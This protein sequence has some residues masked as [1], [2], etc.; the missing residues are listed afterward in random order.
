[1][2]LIPY[3]K[4]YDDDFINT[5]KMV[6][7]FLNSKGE[8][9]LDDIIV[10]QWID[11]NGFT[12]REAVTN[13]ADLPSNADRGDLRGVTS[14]NII[15]MYNG[16]EWV[17]LM[18][19]P[20]GDIEGIKSTLGSVE[21][22]VKERFDPRRGDIDE[23]TARA[24][25][26][27]AMNRKAEELGMVD[28]HFANPH[29]LYNSNNYTT[30]RDMILMGLDAL[31]YKE[32]T[33]VWGRKTYNVNIYG[34]NART[35]TT[36]HSIE[37]SSIE[38]DFFIGGGKTGTIGGRSVYNLLSVAQSKI[39]RD[40]LLS[41][42]STTGADRYTATRHQLNNGITALRNNK[43]L[44][45]N[46]VRFVN[47]DFANGLSGWEVIAG[48]PTLSKKEFYSHPQSLKVW[49]TT[50]QQIRAFLR[51]NVGDIYYVSAYVK[52]TRY[53]TGK[54]GFQ[55][56]RADE[57]DEGVVQRVTDG[58]ELVSSRVQPINDNTY[59]FIGSIEGAN[60]DGWVDNAQMINL[61]EVYG[62]GNEPTKKQM[63]EMLHVDIPA[64]RGMVVE[65]PQANHGYNTDR[66]QVLFEK[67][68]QEQIYPASV[69]K[70]MTAM[71]ALDHV[72]NLD[73]VIKVDSS[74]SAGGSGSDIYAGDMLK[75]SDAFH[76][77]MMESNNTIA[78]TL[79]RVIGEKIAVE[80]KYALH[81]I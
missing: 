81:K 63:D 34:D 76:L 7:D 72:Q 74:D 65:V 50:S 66:L 45:Q 22:E 3:P 70:V 13:K 16:D 62:S 55:F 11:H 14:E 53:E 52:C 5:F 24:A 69:T 77:L 57:L 43:E 68:A 2:A 17:K 25:F 4:Q 20:V 73:E 44:A 19:V 41:F 80:G 42:V 9:L 64:E 8:S 61:T 29:G 18:D 49:G 75:L 56:R 78:K 30:A 27:N 35:I 38:D 10:N 59:L 54:L 39:T 79:E 28:T 23:S 15:Y 1:M 12:S 58:W 6:I 36:N 67:N 21:T 47:G 46:T 60:L 31:S 33:R 51:M 32:L 26:N 40:W 48:S 37:S 71:V